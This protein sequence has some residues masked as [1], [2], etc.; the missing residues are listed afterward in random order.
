MVDYAYVHIWDTLVGVVHWTN[1]Q[2][3][4]FQFDKNFL[5]KKW[6]IAPIKMPIRNDD[7]I[8]SFPNL[9]PSKDNEDDTFKGLPGLL[10][11]SL[12]D[13]YGNQLIEVWLAQNGRPPKSM[14]PG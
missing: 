9:M 13:K 4:N 14:N 2:I 5:N 7:R 8:Y 11:D 3:A 1:Q 6:D 10:A 12:P